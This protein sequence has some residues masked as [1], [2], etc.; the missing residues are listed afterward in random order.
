VIRSGALPVGALLAGALPVAALLLGAA[1]GDAT[2]WQAAQARI[3]RFAVAEMRRLHAPGLAL[4]ITDRER[5]LRVATYGYADLEAKVPVTPEHLFEIGSISKSFTAIALLQ[6]YDAGRFDPHAPITDYLPWFEVRSNYAPITGHDLMTHSAGLP[7]S[8]NDIPSSLYTVFDLRHHVTG[9]LPGA[10]YSYSN[11]GYQTL[12]AALEAIA[13]MPYADIIRKRILEPLGMTRTEATITHD[14]R[15]RLAVGYAPLYD[16]RP[17]DPRRPL[18]RATWLEYALGDGSISSTPADLAAYVRMLLNRGAGPRGRLL[19]PGSFELLT[20]RAIQEE[21]RTWYGYGLRLWDED[22]H[23]LLGHTGG[24]VG[25]SSRMIGDLDAGLGVVAFVNGPETPSRIAAYALAVAR[26]ARAGAPFPPE[27]PARE[28]L[29]RPAGDYAG[30]YTAP[31][32]RMLI[33]AAAGGGLVMTRGGATTR[34]DRAARGD[35]RISLE[36]VD[37]D[38]FRVDHPDFELFLLRFGRDAEGKVVEA[39]FGPDWY[40]GER[41]AGPRTFDVPEEWSTYTGHYRS[42]DPWLSN[43]RIVLRKGAL[44]FIDPDGDE[45]TVTP[46]RGGEFRLDDE[47]S[48]ER[49]RFDSPIDG[50]TLR[51]LLSEEPYYRTF[52]P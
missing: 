16:D 4:A 34:G 38:Q 43:F 39:F 52:T 37:D 14:L 3:D 5:L 27:P 31:D 17:D 51:A 29:A 12:G 33:V 45:R 48:A 19:S 8:Q 18:A 15:R 6:E 10:H 9:A 40:A 22:G 47:D 46:L 1:A 24:M 49:L 32:G 7:D 13:G 20:R 35:G 44:T 50:R 2:R 23:H 42:V 11:V 28:A 26:A 25:Y 36:P 41:Y 30:T 21:D